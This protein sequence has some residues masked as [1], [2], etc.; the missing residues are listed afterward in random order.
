MWSDRAPAGASRIEKDS[1]S[2]SVYVSKSAKRGRRRAQRSSRRLVL[3]MAMIVVG[4]VLVVGAGWAY[5]A[6]ILHGRGELNA[7]AGSGQDLQVS[8]TRLSR[9][10]V[11]GGSAD[12]SI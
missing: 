11:P 9:P 2:N 1:V 3:F 6:V 5:A 10:L 12:G 8:D 4:V 7:P